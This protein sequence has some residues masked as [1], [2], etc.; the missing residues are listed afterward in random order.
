MA[1]TCSK[2]AIIRA[3]SPQLSGMPP[4]RTGRTRGSARLVRI[5]IQSM[6]EPLEIGADQRIKDWKRLRGRLLLDADRLSK[7]AAT[8]LHE[9]RP[10]FP[11]N[12]VQDQVKRPL[13]PPIMNLVAAAPDSPAH[14]WPI[15][16][17][18][19]PLAIGE[20][21]LAFPILSGGN[22]PPP[23]FRFR[24]LEEN[25]EQSPQPPDINSFTASVA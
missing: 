15:R 24:A 9:I 6:S 4:H 21:P 12:C 2:S 5:Y 22:C 1:I 3:F 19:F 20:G 7:L 8:L 10:P 25:G 16:G 13:L 11:A 14:R 18:P 23:A 17:P